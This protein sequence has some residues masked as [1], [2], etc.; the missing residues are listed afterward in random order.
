LHIAVMYSTALQ[1]CIMS[2]MPWAHQ[3]A[4]RAKGCC[5]GLLEASTT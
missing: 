3:R 5:R 1:P 2:I 4:S